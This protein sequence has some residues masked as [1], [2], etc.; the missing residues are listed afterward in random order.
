MDPNASDDEDGR[1]LRFPARF[2]T[3]TREPQ[4]SPIA[5]LGKY[6]RGSDDDY[7]HRM[8]MNAVAVAVVVVLVLCGIWLVDTIAQM[9]KKQDCVLSGRRNCAPINIPVDAR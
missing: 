8:R 3:S 6:S 1:V 9:R 5:D 2:R 7:G 4:R